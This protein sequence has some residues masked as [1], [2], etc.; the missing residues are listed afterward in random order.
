LKRL[1]VIIDGMEDLPYP[2]LDGKTP[3]S[4]AS[5]LQKARLLPPISHTPPGRE[6]DSLACILFMLGAPPHSIPHGRA[7]VEAAAHGIHMREEDLAMRL[8]A[9]G[10]E[11][12]ILVKNG[13]DTNV[14][15]NIGAD[16]SAPFEIRKLDGYRH[17]LI[18]P[19]GKKY[20]DT[21]VTFAPHQNIGRP[22]RELTCAGNDLG[23]ALKE[24]TL[25]L[26]QRYEN[27][28]Y[29]PW[30]PSVYVPLPSFR[31]VS[32]LCGAVVARA[33]VVIGIARLMGMDDY[34]PEGATGD[35]DTQLA[36]KTEAALA[37]VSRYDF[38]LLHINGADEASHRK[39]PR[40]KALFIQRI[41]REVLEPLLRHLPP[42]CELTVTSDHASLCQ[43]GAHGTMKVSR[44]L[45]MR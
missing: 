34:I 21:L 16:V 24:M 17:I 29:M 37:C 5:S 2:E 44:F 1:L 36:A 6:P 31:E 42:G 45:W 13:V 9:V 27:T 25:A 35:V 18:A 26:L 32:G 41:D 15:T 33:D 8:N 23:L 19:G 40:E 10:V 3:L 22:V 20:A 43:T 4:F 28:T 11:N 30:S 12:G 7:F 39:K 14:S 38:T